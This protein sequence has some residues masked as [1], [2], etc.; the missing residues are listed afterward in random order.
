MTTC[1]CVQSGL[2]RTHIVGCLQFDTNSL[3][4][5]MIQWNMP[6]FGSTHVCIISG[7]DCKLQLH[8]WS[9]MQVSHGVHALI[10]VFS[11]IAER[12]SPIPYSAC[13]L[14]YYNHVVLQKECVGGQVR[15]SINSS[16]CKQ[17]SMYETREINV[18]CSTHELS[19]HNVLILIICLQYIAWNIAQGRCCFDIVLQQMPIFHTLLGSSF[20]SRN[21]VHISG[22]QHLSQLKL[23]DQM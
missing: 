12:F 14:F 7:G 10:D 18:C 13:Q 20:S 9:V 8:H 23:S 5:S 19:E 11:C 4:T 1:M 22:Q 15:C 3:L 16:S 21:V 2:L 6:V 17:T